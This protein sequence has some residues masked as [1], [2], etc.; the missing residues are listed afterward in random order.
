MNDPALDRFDADRVSSGFSSGFAS[1]MLELAP[2]AERFAA[3]GYRLYL[4][5]GTVRDLVAGTVGDEFDLDATTD[6]RPSEIKRLLQG[7]ADAV[8]T[9]GERFGTIGA[10]KRGRRGTGPGPAS[11]ARGPGGDDWVERVFEITTHRAEAYEDRSRKPHV[12][13]SDDI[14]SDLSRRDFTVNAMAIEVTSASPTLVDPFDGRSDLA[15]RVLRTP[16]T[17]VES[18]SDD[19]LRMLRAARF[20]AR[21]DLVAEPQLVDAV[22]AMGARLE[23]VSVERI[24]DELDKLLAAPRP[25]A[26]L[27]FAVDTGLL[28]HLAPAV[29]ALRHRSSTSSVHGDALTNAL[30]VISTIDVGGDARRVLR[31]S[32]LL[33]EL[34]AG[35]A[36]DQMRRLR[37]SS[38]DVEAIVT[39][40]EVQRR[41]L[42]RDHAVVERSSEWSDGDVRRLVRDAGR[43]LDEAIVLAR[44][45]AAHLRPA[46][47]RSAVARIDRLEERLVEL[48]ASEDLAQLGPELDGAA[49]MALLQLQPG[50]QVGDAI[51]FLT[52][53][54]LDEGLLGETVAAQRLERWWRD[55]NE[56]TDA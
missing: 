24:R 6:A 12:E 25:A 35:G 33:A 31:W 1:V 47:R 51:S 41:L 48:A 34:G 52:A 44:A 53:L 8:W 23:I 9:Q 7:W 38:A 37:A 18:F 10:M 49:V 16:L 56:R 50:R 21:Y 14:R 20:I 17:P 45:M 15:A 36:R 43:H 54:R 27:R 32:A 22:L 39:L 3:S 13:F 40:V 26:G 4:V 5:G 46:D 11:A 28:S 2:L 55:R 29:D 42:E 30:E 19:P